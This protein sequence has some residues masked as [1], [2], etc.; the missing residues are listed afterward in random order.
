MVS[1][2]CTYISVIIKLHKNMFTQITK[3][4]KIKHK[5]QY[6]KEYN[7]EEN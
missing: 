4:F 5:N 1:L 6:E 7:F 3:D 2:Q